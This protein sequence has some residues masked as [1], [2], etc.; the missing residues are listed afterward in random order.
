MMN[1]L[2]MKKIVLI[3]CYFGKFPWYFDFFL[4]SCATNPTVDFLIFS[5]A[6]YKESLPA[7]VKIVFFTL[8]DFNV[9]ATKKLGFDVL[10]KKPYKLCDFKPAYGILF[11]DFL[12]EYDFWGMC[13]IDVIFG[14]IREFITEDLL[15]E[16]DIINTRHDYLTGSFLLFRNTFEIN[17]LFTKS[18]DYK[19]VFTSDRHFCFDECNFKHAEMEQGISIFDVECEI[20]SMEHVIRKE[21]E[22]NKCAVF[23]DL[24]VIDGLAGKMKWENGVLGYDNKFEILLYHLIQY[25][26]N[27]LSK[28]PSWNDVSNIFY[29][30]QYTFRKK[31]CTNGLGFL[32]FFYHNRFKILQFKSKHFIEYFISVYFWPKVISNIDVGNYKNK[33]GSS[34]LS[35][36]KDSEGKNIVKSHFLKLVENVLIESKFDSNVSFVKSLP[37]EKFTRIVNKNSNGNN[38]QIGYINGN[39]SNYEMIHYLNN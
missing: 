33:L 18:K 23:F 39:I 7:N 4:K 20:E 2:D 6:D 3:N 13:D 34:I 15:S 27:I 29:I 1:I 32:S 31:S 28:N 30:D 19:K 24:L 38:I 17:S 9:L 21:K 35:V 37:N 11:S 16:F 22:A 36:E 12:L 8:E 25:K 26:S 5:D 14:R 10:V